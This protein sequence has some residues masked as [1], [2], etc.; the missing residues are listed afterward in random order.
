M[1]KGCSLTWLG[2]IL[3]LLPGLCGAAP[4][5]P[6]GEDLA[7]AAEQLRGSCERSLLPG[8]KRSQAAIT[9]REYDVMARLAKDRRIKSILYLNRF[10]EVRWA[11]QPE[12]W[13][14]TFER[15]SKQSPLPTDAVSRAMK[16]SA[17]VVAPATGGSYEVAL[18]L[19]SEG[20]PQ[21]ILDIQTDAKGLRGLG[22]DARKALKKDAPI[23][24]AAARTA[25]PKSPDSE[26]QAQQYFLSG[27][28]YFHKGDLAKAR[29][30]WTHA[31]QLDP[32]NPEVSQALKRVKAK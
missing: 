31:A 4:A 22:A 8:L 6:A 5:A 18:P 28:I 16:G 14:M 3:A 25:P 15:L 7:L 26:R 2:L 1:T 13:T 29:G 21:G 10:G 32:G 19:D 11:K 17:A 23:R 30:E 12:L 27:L 9:M 24:P 20:Q